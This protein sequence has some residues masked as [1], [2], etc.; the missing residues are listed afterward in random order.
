MIRRAFE[1]WEIQAMQPSELKTL[2]QSDAD[3]TALLKKGDDT[4]CAER[5]TAI[6][7]PVRASVPAR[8]VQREAALSGAWAS[9]VLA[10]RETS[11]ASASIKGICVTF[12]DWI[13]SAESISLDLP[14][15]APMAAA[16]IEA[17]VI[18]QAQF[19]ALSAMGDVRQTVTALDVEFV[20]TRI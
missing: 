16:L 19:D 10:S 15:I 9:I 1:I 8:D 17:K 2:I 7:P 3:A 11:L 12:I 20:R 14:Q 6:A 4:G 5:C 13:R 18:T